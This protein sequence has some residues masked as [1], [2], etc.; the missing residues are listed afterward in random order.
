ML[1]EEDDWLAWDGE[2][3]WYMACMNC[4]VY[5]KRNSVAAPRF[6]KAHKGCRRP[7]R[8]GDEVSAVDFWVRKGSFMDHWRPAYGPV[9]ELAALG[10]EG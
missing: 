10:R 1:E 2:I 7:N 9:E 8:S 4:G 3:E 6:R 5:I